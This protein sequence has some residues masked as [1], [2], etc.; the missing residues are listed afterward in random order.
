MNIAQLASDTDDALRQLGE[1]WFKRLDEF[2]EEKTDM[3][4]F[5]SELLRM[6]YAYARLTALSTGLKHAKEGQLNEN[7]FIMRVGA[8]YS[9]DITLG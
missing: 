7:T 6:A 4:A 2:E 8:C 9:S 3:W 1:R 5:R